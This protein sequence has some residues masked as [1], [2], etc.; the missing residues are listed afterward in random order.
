MGFFS[1]SPRFDYRQLPGAN[2]LILP[3]E[4]FDPYQ[5]MRNPDA[6]EKGYKHD[7]KDFF[8]GT[9][10]YDKIKGLMPTLSAIDSAYSQG[11]RLAENALTTGAGGV[12]DQ[13]LARQQAAEIQAQNAQRQASDKLGAVSDYRREAT[14]GYEGA[15]SNRFA[16]ALQAGALGLQG[17][18]AALSGYLNSFKPPTSYGQSPFGIAKSIAGVAAAPFTGGASLGLASGGGG[19]FN[20]MSADSSNIFSSIWNGMKRPGSKY[21]SETAALGNNYFGMG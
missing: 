1:G 5:F 9:T 15:R 6:V 21:G 17:K 10:P 2:D 18:E 11:N 12:G 14:S 7:V 8:S 4:Y 19:G 16:Q 20:P 3:L 13:D